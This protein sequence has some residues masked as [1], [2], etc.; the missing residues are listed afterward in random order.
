MGGSMI[1]DELHKYAHPNNIS[2]KHTK[3]K[4]KPILI[5]EEN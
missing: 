3:M 4:L 5:K 1:E 2:I